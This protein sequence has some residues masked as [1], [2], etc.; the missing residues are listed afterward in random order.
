MNERSNTRRHRR[1]SVQIVAT[2]TTAGETI[3]VVTKDVSRGGICVFSP[4]G[5]A[6]GT[7]V[8]LSLSLVL[9]D[10]AFSESLTLKGKVVWST[11]LVDGFQV[12]ATF[13]EMDRE[14]S[15]FLDMFLRF[16]EQEIRVP[17]ASEP[18]PVITQFDIGDADKP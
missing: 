10:N 11:P 18:V 3:S 7:T 4:S 17:R 16:V 9:G 5:I 1:F 6:P 14:K 2:I 13:I 12:G 15:G 8:D